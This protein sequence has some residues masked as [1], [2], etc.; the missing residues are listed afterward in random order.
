MI[1][2]YL[3]RNKRIFALKLRGKMKIKPN[4]R[5]L[6][7]EKRLMPFRG[8]IIFVT[9]VIVTHFTWRLF[10][11]TGVE[12]Q[13][14]GEAL[15]EN[16][17]VPISASLK[18]KVWICLGVGEI[19]R[20]NRDN[21]YISL[22]NKNL[23]SYF[24]PWAERTAAVNFWVVNTL[25][26]Q[27]LFFM[28]DIV[29]KKGNA[30]H[31]VL[32]YDKLHGPAINII[33]GCTGVKQ[34]YIFFFVILFSQGIWW[35]RLIYFFMGSLV[36]LFFNVLRISTVIL[37]MKPY[38]GSF[39]LLHDLVFKYLFYGIIFLLWILWEEKRIKYNFKKIVE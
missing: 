30:Y 13:E 36:L 23:T 33:W 14:Y 5:L 25:C 16:G 18:E 6:D 2:S 34:L 28:D 4:D 1:S 12:N 32:S 8:I 35:K 37:A 10:I 3:I 39:E 19:D 38:P 22:L 7:W 17:S 20:K 15:V 11:L 31:T 26:R 29:S 24:I 9:V 21:Q 27:R